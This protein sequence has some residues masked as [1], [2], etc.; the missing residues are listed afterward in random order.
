MITK[1]IIKRILAPYNSKVCI[2][3]M[4]VMEV[5]IGLYKELQISK[6]VG[7]LWILVK[8]GRIFLVINNNR[9]IK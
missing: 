8:K 4:I 2:K 6:I 7:I 9:V 1:P 3:N 5:L